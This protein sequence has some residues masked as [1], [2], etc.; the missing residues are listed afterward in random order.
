[1]IIRNTGQAE[2]QAQLW[3]DSMQGSTSPAVKGSSEIGVRSFV[4]QFPSIAVLP[5]FPTYHP[6]LAHFALFR[7]KSEL[8]L[9][10]FATL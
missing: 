2:T 8:A 5:I 10:F 3:D 7:G 1:L 9:F 6:Y 4:C